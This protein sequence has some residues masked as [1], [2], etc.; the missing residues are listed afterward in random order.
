MKISPELIPHSQFHTG[1]WLKP[2][3]TDWYYFLKKSNTYAITQ[4]GFMES[5]DKPL[6]KLVK[7]LH[8]RGIK[9]TPS[10]AGHFIRNKDLEKKFTRLQ[11]DG[12]EIRNGGLV[13][14]DVQNGDKYLFKDKNYRLPWNKKDYVKA[15][16][17]YQQKGVIGIILKNNTASRK[18]LLNLDIDGLKVIDK[19]PV[20][21]FLMDHD[22]KKENRRAW[23]RLTKEIKAIL[24]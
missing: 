14:S 11:K 4:A 19:R 23:K 15:F 18:Q 13:L 20:L 5:V 21:L 10:C 24:N 2:Q 9:T 1:V 3:E 8:S 12:E 22:R 16:D 17:R 7:Y 6:K